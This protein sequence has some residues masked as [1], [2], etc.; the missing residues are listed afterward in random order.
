MTFSKD[1]LE[2]GQK[3][4]AVKACPACGIKHADAVDVCDCGVVL[5]GGGEGQHALRRSLPR[6]PRPQ[7]K[8]CGGELRKIG[9]Y[10]V[11]TTYQCE[12]C[13]E[14]RTIEDAGKKLPLFLLK[15]YY[16]L[17]GLFG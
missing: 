10:G 15:I 6:W 2:P 17:R 16:G 13:G 1:Q 11:E 9:G 14:I 5:S 8:S 4:K 7:C 3:G 12:I